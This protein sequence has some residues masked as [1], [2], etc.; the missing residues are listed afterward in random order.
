MAFPD[1]ALPIKV[2]IQAGSWTDITSYVRGEQQIRITRGRQDEGGSTEPSRC[3]FTLDNNDHRFTPGNPTGPYYGLIGRNTPCRVSVL[4]GSVYLDLTGSGAD[5]AETVDNAALDITGDIDVRLDATLAN[6]L[7]PVGVFD[8]TTVDLMGKFQ[9][10]TQKSWMLSTRAGRLFFEWS[11]DGTNSLSASS[12]VGPVIPGSG[13][14]AIRATLDVNNTVGG[15]V[16]TFYTAETIDGPWVQLGDQVTQSGTTSIFNS[17]SPVRIGNAT[18]IAYLQPFGRVHAA[19]IRN[20]I[21]GTAVANPVFSAQSVGATSFADA[22]GRTWTINGGASITNRKTR[23]VGEI[24]AWPRRWETKFDVTVAAEAAG[25]MRRLSQ[26]NTPVRSAMYRELTNP[27]R[28]HIVAYW[29]MEDGSAATMLGSAIDGV[30]A[31]ALSSTGVSPA[32]YSDWA[33]SDA[34]PTFTTGN[35]RGRLPSYTATNYAFHRFFAEVP[36]GGVSTTQRLYTFTTSGTARTWSLY[37][38]SSGN[39]DLRAFDGDGTQ[40]LSTGFVVLGINGRPVHIGIELT[41]SGADIGYTLIVFY[42]DTST[43]TAASQGGATGTL[44]GN[45]FGTIG[46]IRIGQDGGLA[47]TAVGHVAVADDS[48]AYAGTL[49]AMIAWDGEDAA[50]RL[51]RLADEEGIALYEVMGADMEMGPQRSVT[52]LELLRECEA[53]D[54]GILREGREFLGFSYRDRQSMYSQPSAMDIDYSGDDGLVTPLEPTDDDQRVRNDRTVQRASGGSAR[55]ALDTGALSTQAPPSGVGRYDDSTTLNLF[56]DDQPPHIANWLLHLGTWDA[57]RYPTVRLLLQNATHMIEDAVLLDS[58][59]RFRII[60][61]PAWEPPDMGWI[62]LMVQG[63]TET[64]S[65]FQWEMEFNCAP[66]GSWDTAWVG[67]AST[68]AVVREWAWTDTTGSELTEALTST[69]TDVDVLTT[70]GPIWSPNVRDTPFDWRVGGEVVTVT[71]PGGLLNT[72][73]F[74][75]VSTT[76]WT[77]S[78][79]GISR[80]TTAGRVLPHPRA[81]ASLLIAPDGVSAS[82][83]A[84]GTLTAAGTITPGAQYVASM[85]VYSAGGWSDLRPCIDWYTSSGVFISTSLGSASSVPAGQWTYLEQTLAAPAT[86]S[87]AIVRARHG[88]TP[89]AAST[90]HAWGVRI[91]QPTSSWLLDTFSR[92]SASGWGQADSGLSWS[93]VGGGSATDYTL[94]GTYASHVL[95]TVDTSRRTGITAVSAD[96]DIYCDLTT[97]ATATG[98]SLFGAIC[99]RMLD[100]N[101]LYMARLEWTTGNAVIL[102]VRKIVAGVQTQLATYTIPNYTHVAGTFLRVRFQGD[103]SV[104]RAKV[105]RTT[106]AEPSRWHVDTTDTALTAANQIGTR[107]IR[108]TGNTNLATVEVRFDNFEV[109]NPQTYTVTR[110]QNGVVKNQ[111]TGAAV[112]LATPA[113]LAL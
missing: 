19:E 50:V 53:A 110:S 108:V 9:I 24:S 103:G 4:T 43:L 94:S 72:N 49:G 109:V 37:V 93:S 66:A 6:W 41:Q 92:S 36:S 107:S 83:G 74:F 45:T 31:M 70:D 3:S 61:P 20:G 56:D 44:A 7:T 80:V 46:E 15:N 26:G 11:A 87:R 48:T 85:W 96:F 42:I 76:G 105:W 13:R 28:T 2:E 67:S 52:L 62:D 71:A 51:G 60:N 65:Q 77:G 64:I 57:T 12:T 84:N 18:N 10:N 30:P 99:G 14:L 55:A 17:T 97:S 106:D 1:T 101:N 59:D 8:T 23:F 75:D 58:G 102:S 86:A 111:S 79:A 104:L 81:V 88:G 25:I 68:A 54:G 73:P 89:S 34:I 35:A 21:N 27:S 39:L 113:Y 33:A 69:E 47:G 5:F 90:W 29:P 40:I 22:A 38:N 112:A 91:T 82:G 100:A 98:D 95:A 63:Y 16:V 32:G 78:N